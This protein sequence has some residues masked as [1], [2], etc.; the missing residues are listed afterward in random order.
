MLSSDSVISNEFAAGDSKE[1]VFVS[2]KSTC[3]NRGLIC[4]WSRGDVLIVAVY[5]V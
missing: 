1:I 5:K 4:S 3:D 2:F